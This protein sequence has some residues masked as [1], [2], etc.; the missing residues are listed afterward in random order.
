MYACIDLGSNSFHLLIAEWQDGRSQIVE[1]FSSIVQLGE[2]VPLTGEISPAAFARGIDCLR[3]FAAAMARHPVR[4]YWALGTNA[5]RLARNAPEFLAQ[6]KE[7]GLDVSVISGYQEAILV[8][9]GVLSGLPSSDATRMVIDIGG[10][11]TEVIIGS[12]ELRHVTQSL[13]IGCVSWRDRFFKPLPTDAAA[14][15]GLLATATAEAE[16]VF[17]GVRDDVLRYP[18]TEIYAS[19]GTAKMLSLV[20]QQGGYTDSDGGITLAALQRLKADVIACAAD[21]EL[22]LPGLK[23]RRK[24]L[25]MPGWAVLTGLMQTFDLQHITFSPTALREG[26]LEFMMRKGTDT[27]LLD[28]DTLP[29]ISRQPAL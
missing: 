5:L 27:S 12:G 21:P 15:E 1:R 9:A 16:K 8:Y 11:S 26:M 13:P 17:A 22:L 14:L 7:L 29:R 28:G 3:E 23:D 2:G 10:G 6:A 4:R 25:L 20:C 24:D 19:S 18:C